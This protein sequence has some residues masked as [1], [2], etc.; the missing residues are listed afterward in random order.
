MQVF[1]TKRRNSAKIWILA[2]FSIFTPVLVSWFPNVTKFFQ[3]D[4]IFLKSTS[5]ANTLVKIRTQAIQVIYLWRHKF[6]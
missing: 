1:A 6:G 4:I 3:S 5:C 2:L